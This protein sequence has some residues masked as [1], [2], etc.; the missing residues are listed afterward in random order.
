MRRVLATGVLVLAMIGFLSVDGAQARDTGKHRAQARI[1]LM[2]QETLHHLYRI[3]PGARREIQRAAGYAVF[4]DF[5][6]HIFFL[7]T[8]RGK[9]IA[10]NNRTK[11]ETFMKMLSAGAGPGMGIKDYRV[12]FLFETKKSFRDFTHVGLELTAQADAAAKAG[13]EGAAF[14]GAIAVADGVWVYQ[15]TEAG[16][17][18]QA[19][20]QETKYYRASDLN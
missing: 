1:R 7:S 3:H 11:K 4:D 8:A 15:I 19:T 16:L 6:A 2:A 13:H 17:A 20:L 14:A 10:V 9:G 12:I 5:G 18:L